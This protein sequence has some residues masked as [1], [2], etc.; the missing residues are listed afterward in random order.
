MLSPFLAVSIV[1]VLLS[2]IS[3]ASV[4]RPIHPISS[5]DLCGIWTDKDQTNNGFK[6]EEDVESC[7]GE[8]ATTSSAEGVDFASDGTYR[9]T[10][11]MF[12]GN[13][14]PTGGTKIIK[15]DTIGTY[16]LGGA[17]DGQAGWTKISYTPKTHVV[18]VYK[19]NKI[20]PHTASVPGPCELPETF[21]NDPQIGCPCNGTWASDGTNRT[22]IKANCPNGTCLNDFWFNDKIS[23][24]NLKLINQTDQTT[25]EGDLSLFLSD[26]STQSAQVGYGL[27]TIRYQKVGGE[28]CKENIDNNPSPTTPSS[29]VPCQIPNVSLFFL[30]VFLLLT[31]F[32]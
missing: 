14:D 23:Y 31:E 7:I 18:W 9:L 26:T 6:C 28:G 19:N 10:F 1:I 27:T 8:T 5:S 16:G 30:L 2:T 24:G 12:T 20:M 22:I 29:T 4:D 17:N 25:G 3:V 32:C 11:M 13:C 15:V 21:L